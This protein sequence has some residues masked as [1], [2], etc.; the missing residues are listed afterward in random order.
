MIFIITS[1]DTSSTQSEINKI[2]SALQLWLLDNCLKLNFSKTKYMVMKI[3]NPNNDQYSINMNGS[4]IDKVTSYKYLGIILDDRLKCQDHITHMLNKLKAISAVIYKA[5]FYMPI[6]ILKNIYF[7]L[8]YSILNYATLIWS[9]SAKTYIGKI[10]TINN[11]ILK[12]T[13]K[14]SD[15]SS[16]ED[17]LKYNGIFN[18]NQ[19]I[20]F[21]IGICGYKCYRGLNKYQINLKKIRSFSHCD[22]L[23]KYYQ[24]FWLPIITTEF[25]RNSIA[26][27]IGTTFNGIHS[28]VRDITSLIHF[29]KNLKRFLFFEGHPI[30][31]F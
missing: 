22:A 29:K 14:I 2:I 23:P 1:S 16:L 31:F 21:K 10:T 13:L 19:L 18:V 6:Y 27:R 15:N 9:T 5:K 11:R 25:H 30:N 7:A 8:A 20:S 24:I 12:S 28:L 3:K 17:A 26:N 4:T